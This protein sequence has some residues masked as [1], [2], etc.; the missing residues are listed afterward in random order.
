M[1]APPTGGA[2]IARGHLL[3]RNPDPEEPEPPLVEA[4]VPHGCFV[5]AVVV[6]GAVSPRR[7]GG[8]KWPIPCRPRWCTVSP[9]AGAVAPR[10]AVEVA[11]LGI[12]MPGATRS[13]RPARSARSARS[14][15]M[16]GR[17]STRTAGPAGTA[18]ST[19]VT[20]S[21]RRPTRIAGA[22]RSARA[23]R[24]TRSARIIR[25][26]RAVIPRSRS[27]VATAGTR[28][29]SRCGE[30]RTGTDAQRSGAKG[31]DDRSPRNKLLQFH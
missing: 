15:G 13:A 12:A 3:Q 7:A 17:G 14:A 5:V 9:R 22:T 19:G 4:G 23:T 18:G 1:P 29:L 21:A 27:T 30:R 16:V 2:D 10:G 8:R 28:R 6:D 11:A 25:S 24:A 20:G 31:A 26:G